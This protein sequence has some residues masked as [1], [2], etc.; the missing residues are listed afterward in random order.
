LTPSEMRKKKIK[1]VLTYAF[2]SLAD[3]EGNYLVVKAYNYTNITSIMLLDCFSIP[4]VMILSRA[5][6]G[7]KYTKK[8]LLSV[9]ICIAGL[10]TLVI[11]DY[12]YNPQEDNRSAREVVLGDFL[13]ICGTFFYAISNVGQ[14]S[15]IKKFDKVEWLSFLGVFGSIISFVQLMILESAELRSTDWNS[16][17]ELPV[18]FCFVG[19]TLCLFLLY[20]LVPTLIQ[21]ESATLFN[22]SILTSDFFAILASIFLFHRIVCVNHYHLCTNDVV[23]FRSVLCCLCNHFVWIDHVQ[24]RETTTIFSAHNLNEFKQMI[25][26]KVRQ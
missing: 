8:N 17:D 21:M 13:C 12:F 26:L 4:F 3:V 14:E 1:K 23:A 24:I 18:V 5:F 16:A 25:N 20:S 7:T 19:F 15:M 10:V 9:A 22:L 6:L 2:L 11:S